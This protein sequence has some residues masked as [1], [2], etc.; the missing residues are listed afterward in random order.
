MFEGRNFIVRNFVNNDF[1][2][3]TYFHSIKKTLDVFIGSFVFSRKDANSLLYGILKFFEIIQLPLNNLH[4]IL[5]FMGNLSFMEIGLI[6]SKR[7]FICSRKQ[8]SFLYLCGVDLDKFSD[9]I[10]GNSVFTIY[11]GSFFS[12]SFQKDVDLILPVAVYT[13]G[14]YHYLI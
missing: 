9:V 10:L 7:N 4:V 14:V 13:E 1:T 11:Q 3:L 8:K 5:P 2:N 12:S 6:S